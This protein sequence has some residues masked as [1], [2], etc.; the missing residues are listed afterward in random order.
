MRTKDYYSEFIKETR[1]IIREQ[2]Q[3]AVA[4]DIVREMESHTSD[5]LEEEKRAM[6]T[7]PVGDMTHNAL[8]EA[9]EGVSIETLEELDAEAAARISSILEEKL[10][11]SRV[12]LYPQTRE[13]TPGEISR[14]VNNVL[15]GL[16]AS[17]GEH[18]EVS[19]A[20]FDVAYAVMQLLGADATEDDL[21]Y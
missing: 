9:T 8:T 13:L 14:I 16:P 1:K 19:D 15:R 17:L 4:S 7:D 20:C 21:E 3:S 11:A 18:E 6:R 2:D 10:I 12:E 5:L